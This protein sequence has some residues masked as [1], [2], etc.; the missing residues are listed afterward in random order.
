MTSGLTSRAIVDG[1]MLSDPKLP[2]RRILLEDGVPLDDCLSRFGGRGS[3]TAP[4][5]AVGLPEVP[6]SSGDL[7]MLPLRRILLGVPPDD[8]LSRLGG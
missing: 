5:W 3:V 2:R 6:P 8:C 4:E 1:F 7:P